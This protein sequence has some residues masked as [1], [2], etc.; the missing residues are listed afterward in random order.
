MGVYE[1]TFISLIIEGVF[2]QR[3]NK[4]FIKNYEL[5]GITDQAYDYDVFD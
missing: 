4:R 5:S 2:T 3:L 1:R